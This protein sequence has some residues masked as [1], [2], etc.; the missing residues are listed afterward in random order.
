MS[1]PSLVFLVISL[2]VIFPH[3]C[4]LATIRLLKLAS[5]VALVQTKCR[6]QIKGTSKMTKET[7]PAA[8]PVAPMEAPSMLRF[9]CCMIVIFFLTQGSFSK[10]LACKLLRY[11]ICLSYCCYTYDLNILG[12]RIEALDSSSQNQRVI[13]ID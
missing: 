2:H 13:G 3:T 8:P 6:S 5:I 7:R 9:H 4:R 12:T 10:S 11:C 1:N